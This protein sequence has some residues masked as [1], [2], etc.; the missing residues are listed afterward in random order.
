MKYIRW[1]WDLTLTPFYLV[2][3]ALA[4]VIVLISGGP[5]E[6]FDFWRRNK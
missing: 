2:L 5:K 3:I 6:F 1:L 4:S